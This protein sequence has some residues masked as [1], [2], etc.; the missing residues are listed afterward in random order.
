V[1]SLRD[2][3]DRAALGKHGASKDQAVIP[4]SLKYTVSRRA[5]QPTP[6]LRRGLARPGDEVRAEAHRGHSWNRVRI[7]MEE[8]RVV[9]R[10]IRA[11]GVVGAISVGERKAVIGEDVIDAWRDLEH[12]RPSPPRQNK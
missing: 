6:R 2:M 7:V 4:S 12:M 3:E 11:A 9:R 10:A 1:Y 5:A 8:N